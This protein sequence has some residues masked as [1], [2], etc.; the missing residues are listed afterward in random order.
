MDARRLGYRPTNDMEVVV[1][2]IRDLRIMFALGAV[3]VAAALPTSASAATTP[4]C[5]EAGNGHLGGSYVVTG[6]PDPTPP[7]R[8]TS[9]LKTLGN[10]KGNGLVNAA[11]KSPALATCGLPAPTGGTGGGGGGTVTPPPAS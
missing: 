2:L 6:T 5:N 4:V 1:S 10:G 11:A 3:A 9:G 8:H 7:A